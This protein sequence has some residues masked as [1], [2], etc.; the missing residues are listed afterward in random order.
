LGTGTR[1]YG[2]VAEDD[3][4]ILD[5]NAVRMLLRRVDLDRR[6]AVRL[7]GGDVVLPLAAGQV[8]VDG[9]AVEVR[10][11]PVGEARRCAS[12]E[13]NRPSDRSASR[14]SGTS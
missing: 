6:E 9:H 12:H 14:R 2:E 8:D 11:L 13:G 3:H 5:E 1:E 4:G 7:E 10:E